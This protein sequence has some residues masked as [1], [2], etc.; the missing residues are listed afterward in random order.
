M[1][2][3]DEVPAQLR[4]LWGLSAPAKRGRPAELDGG[5]VVAAAVGLADR[6]GLAGVTLAK[7]AKELGYSPMSLYRYMGSMDELL[8]LMVDAAA[9]DAEDIVLRRGRWRANLRVWAAT[10]LRLAFRHPW[11][12]HVPLTGPPSGPNQIK[13]M[14]KGLAALRDTGLDWPQ[15]VGIISLVSGYVRTFALQSEGL[16]QG[17]EGTGMDQPEAEAAWAMHLFQLVDAERFP[18]VAALMSSDTFSGPPPPPSDDPADDPDFGYGL[19]RI[20]D[21]VAVSVAAAGLGGHDPTT[22]PRGHTVHGVSGSQDGSCRVRSR[23]SRTHR[24]R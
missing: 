19:E 12:H 6:E 21:G 17:R 10:Q 4:R 18:E 15:K 13:W 7:V 9:A 14:D 11:L 5:K 23:P 3:K 22:R 2:A 16:R 8:Q 1:T 20:L 24:P